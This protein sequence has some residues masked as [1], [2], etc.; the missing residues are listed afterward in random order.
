V[1]SGD[2]GWHTRV[3][4]SMSDVKGRG[5]NAGGVLA[6]ASQR[7]ACYS[8]GREGWRWSTRFRLRVASI[9]AKTRMRWRE[10][11][12][13]EKSTVRVCIMNEIIFN[14]HQSSANN[15]T[16]NLAGRLK[17][18]VAAV[19]R[20]TNDTSWARG[21]TASRPALLTVVAHRTHS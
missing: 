2:T 1:R 8:R 3:P 6:C 11:G 5:K 18:Q 20:E 9:W 16:R 13:G 14:Q 4:G 10:G 17:K 19:E 21:A 7:F 12:G 15:D